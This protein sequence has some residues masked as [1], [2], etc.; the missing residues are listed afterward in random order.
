MMALAGL[1]WLPRRAVI[2]IGVAI[3]AG[4]NLLDSITPDQLGGAGWVWTLVHEGGLVLFR[5]TPV[6]LAAYPVLPWIGVIAVGYGLGPVFLEAP[7]KRERTLLWLGLA[8]LAAFLSLRGFDLYGEPRPWSAQGGVIATAMGFLDVSKYPP[9]LHYTLVTLG[10][11]FCLWGPLARMPRVAAR[12]L[13]VFGAVPFL[14]Y[15]LHVYLVHL[16]AIVANAATGRD[17][18]GLFDFMINAFSNKERLAGLGFSLP[19][20]YLVTA[21][22][23]VLLYPV[24]RWWGE[25]KRTRRDWWLSYL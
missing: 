15:V 18:S 5:G 13:A 17:A 7:A 3:V 20:V 24:C 23:L 6:G 22:V 14:F 19:Y 11:V 4:H 2:A 21:V 10:L 12:V 25:V 16:L 1:V 9:S 8:M